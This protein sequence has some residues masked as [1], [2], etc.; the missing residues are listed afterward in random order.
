MRASRGSKC[1]LALLLL[2][3]Q[4]GGLLADSTDSLLSREGEPANGL[5]RATATE[6]D[7]LSPERPGYLDELVILHP[8]DEKGFRNSGD[9][10]AM[11]VGGSR[12]LSALVVDGANRPIADVEIR[13]REVSPALRDMG[14]VRTDSS[15]VA[16]I[17][18]KA[19]EEAETVTILA[20]QVSAEDRGS[21]ITY[22][23]PVKKPSWALFMVFGLVGGLALFIF[24]MDM[25]SASLQRTAGRRMRDALRLFT[26]NRFIAV[27][28]GALV[29]MAI[30]S[31]SAT[32]VI[33]VSFV[34]AGLMSFGQTL[35]VILGADIGTTITAQLIAFRLTDFALL[36]IAVGFLLK[37]IGKQD[38]IRGLG[39]VIFGSGVL[40]FGLSIMSLA[41]SPLRDYRLFHEL[42]IR[43]ENPILGIL[44]GAAFTALI[45]SS[46]AFAGIVIVLAQQGF[47]SLGAG[48]PLIFGANIGTCITAVLA[49]LNA[50]REA[51]RVALAHVLF[52]VLGVLLMVAW[53]PQFTALVAR[54][55]GG[56]PIARQVA[57]AHTV[58]NVGIALVFLPFTPLFARLIQ[59]MLPDKPEAVRRKKKSR[60]LDSTM[61]NAPALALNLAKV[62]ILRMGEKVKWMA[63]R[64][65]EAFFGKD[66]TVLDRI[67]RGENTVD[68][69]D[70]EISEYLIDIGKQKLSEEQAEEVYMMMHVTKQYEHIAD[71]IDKNLRPLARKM[72]AE[73]VEFSESGIKEVKA[74]HLKMLKQIS[75]SLEAFR[76]SS[77]Q[78]A[79]HVEKKHR[80]YQH[81][82]SDYRMAHYHRIRQ[83]VAESVQSNEYHLD[84]MDALHKI[85]SYS[86]NVARA[87]LE[88]YG[89]DEQEPESD[90][91]EPS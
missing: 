42:L 3:V 83:A 49:S 78:A 34:R 17:F 26:G 58:F 59:R 29:T 67:H 84:I 38:R 10:Q 7:S 16:R 35:G 64:I 74:F 30:Q 85:D 25:L 70:R 28:A 8:S 18:F 66:L 27:A 14:I 52:K 32:T 55:S 75:R 89:E 33:L 88:V 15:G 4:A 48:I 50:G 90:S 81:I 39:D 44:F 31:S 77:L 5:S 6:S 91:G 12:E 9:R 61:L 54:I 56:A 57:N 86:T 76:D 68:A 22:V 40:F 73:H 71:I 80:R 47:I 21:G 37:Y 13:F 72:A 46:A 51:K 63:E 82:E 2:A 23:I 53:I 1:L 11:L 41:M 19:G 87:L 43:L 36:I 62:E 69:L 60:H 24:G 79:L 65:P 45:Q 20:M